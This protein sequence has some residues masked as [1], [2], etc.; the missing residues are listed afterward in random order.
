[1]RITDLTIFNN[2]LFNVGRNREALATIQ[3]QISTLRKI[4]KP[5]DSPE[6]TG[7]LI[8]LQNQL[9]T[10]E[11]Y[12]KNIFEGLSFFD[13]TVTSMETIQT[14]TANVLTTLAN[15]NNAVVADNLQ[16]FADQIDAALDAILNSAN[17]KF[18][19]KYLFAGTDYST[20]PFGYNADG[21]AIE[22]KVSDISG[23]QNIQI[24]R[25][26]IQK[27]NMTG[28]EIFGTI[29]KQSGNLDSGA[30][31]GDVQTNQTSVYS[32]DGTE[33]TFI[34]SY[35]KTA[36]NTYKLSYDIQDSGGSSV[37]LSP[38]ASHQIVF[39]PLTGEMNT[40][41]G[42]PASTIIIEA[43]SQ[44]IQ[45]IFDPSK[46]KESAN[47]TSLSF[48]ANQKVDIFNTLLTIK[49]K[50]ENGELPTDEEVARVTNFNKHILNK[51]ANAGNIINKLQDTK[52]VLSNQQF[53]LTGLISDE[54]DVD[55]AKAILELQNQ[56]YILQ[57][58]Y[59]ISS[60]VLPKSLLDYI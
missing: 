4:Q 46:I 3:S 53:V 27:I 23:K 18:N 24:S 7:K 48:S 25:N 43:P 60:M 2:Y 37:F 57:L 12:S 39:D 20:S 40:I 42:K 44:N 5:S 21:S 11:R 16:T 58:S 47:S 26:I 55:I 28:A 6:G 10:S 38:P 32:A 36:D 59:K 50:L 22:I 51:L 31:I 15:A 54:Q 9:R 45:F 14:S 52:D 56:D 13:V 8:R 33:F 34:A 41:N 19:G 1:M 49:N 17:Q 30:S 29:V 35:T